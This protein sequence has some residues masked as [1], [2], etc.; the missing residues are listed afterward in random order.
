MTDEDEADAR[1]DS[2]LAENDGSEGA[3]EDVASRPSTDQ[4]DDSNLDKIKDALDRYTALE[5]VK[6]PGGHRSLLQRSSQQEVC[7]LASLLVYRRC[8]KEVTVMTELLDCVLLGSF[9]PGY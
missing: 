3:P 8:L 5:S 2:D 4:V 9:L 1:L 7:L 6:I